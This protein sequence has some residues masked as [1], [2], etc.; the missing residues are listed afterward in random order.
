MS[1]TSELAEIAN[2]ISNKDPAYIR[3]YASI[4]A[5]EIIE[6][7][8]TAAKQLEQAETAAKNANDE[9][10]IGF[11]TNTGKE[12]ARRSAKAIVETN[13][14]V[15][16]LNEIVRES[17]GI[18]CISLEFANCMSEAI[19][20]MLVTGFTTRDGEFKKLSGTS[21]KQAEYI[22][23]QAK[24]FAQSQ[25]QQEAQ[26]QAL[27]DRLTQN[28][29]LAEEQ[30]CQINQLTDSVLQ[31]AQRLD[32]KDSLDD[33]QSK[34]IEALGSENK[35]QNER[36]EK[37]SSENQSQNAKLSALHEQLASKNSL[38]DEQS[39]QIEALGSENKSQNEK[40]EKLSS[41]NQSQN[42]K[43][44]ALHEHLTSK[45]SLDDE[46][47]KQI[48]ELR[49]ELAIVKNAL[50]AQNT[51]TQ[52]ALASSKKINTHLVLIIISFVLSSIAIVLHF[53]KL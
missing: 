36:L 51:N 49:S 41:E 13:K 7:L 25:I 28:E 27:Q 34:Q 1:N 3:A 42:A 5:K 31:N 18:A 44:S 32:E 38:D 4:K 14:A 43:L 22:L 35:S 47:S 20:S 23:T 16:Q 12:V 48:E 39:K 24:Q 19:A 15:M 33:K 10:D 30:T 45:D 6:K 50:E 2:E 11:F 17:I 37:L 26:Y 46:Q 29:G 52:L 21:K 9:S 53:I 8:D 40:L